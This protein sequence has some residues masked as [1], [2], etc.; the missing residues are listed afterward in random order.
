MTDPVSECKRETVLLR[1][2]LF[3]SY[4]PEEPALIIFT[5]RCQLQQAPWR[6]AHRIPAVNSPCLYRAQI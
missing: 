1:Q 3:F 5:Y 4:E 6:N 2:S